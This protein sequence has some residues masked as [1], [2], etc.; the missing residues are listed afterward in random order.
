MKLAQR[1]CLVAF[2]FVTLMSGSGI[3]YAQANAAKESAPVGAV[4]FV[5]RDHNGKLLHDLKADDLVV[6]DNGHGAKILALEP[7]PKP[8][9]R[10]GIL[11]AGDQSTFKAQQAAAIHV[12]E[13]LRP[14]IDQAFVLNQAIAVKPHAWADKKLN[15]ESDLKKLATFVGGL[16]WNEALPNTKD[17]VMGM[18]ALNP[19][20]PFRRVMLEFRDPEVETGVAYR[21]SPTE[22]LAE[23]DVMEIKEFQ[24]RRAI[25]Y[26]T[27]LK[28]LRPL[29]YNFHPAS[30]KDE[31]LST[32]TGGRYL[33]W[34]RIESDIAAVPEDLDNQ[35]LLV[36]EAQP[37]DAQQPQRLE[38]RVNR[39][40]VRLAYPDHFYP[41]KPN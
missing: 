38:I 35:Q 36:F 18:L 11:L 21:T 20:K 40:D 29:Q 24:R 19:D 8:P 6:L 25:V 10:I 39:K 7:A 41:L 27:T 2:L 15:W 17:L 9:V 5:A 34:D 32:S 31:R 28:T 16:H 4:L 23:I 1:S 26:T 12:L 14:G 33:I 22:E 3:G 30:V 13:H 37:G